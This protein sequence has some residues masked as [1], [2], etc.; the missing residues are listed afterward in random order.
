MGYFKRIY[1]RIEYRIFVKTNHL[2]ENTYRLLDKM[3]IFGFCVQLG[4]IF[5]HE[6]LNCQILAKHNE[7][8]SST[9]SNHFN[10][11]SAKS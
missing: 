6:N 3:T 2:F 7:N 11:L 8:Q 5:I 1:S 4:C 10:S 9:Y